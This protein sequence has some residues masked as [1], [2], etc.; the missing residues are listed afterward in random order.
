MKKVFALFL[1]VCMLFSM[2]ACAAKQPPANAGEENQKTDGT[3]SGEIEILWQIDGA[4]DIWQYTLD[5]F[6]EHYPDVKIT[7]NKDANAYESIGNRLR[8]GNPPDVFYTWHTAFDY[9]S[10]YKSGLLAPVDALM[11]TERLEG[12]MT[13]KEF[14]Q[15]DIYESGLYEGNHYFIPFQQLM[16]MSFYSGKTFEERNYTVPTTWDEF[17]SLCDQ[18]KADGE[19]SPVIYAGVY[20]EML[21]NTFVLNEIYNND[22]ET[23]NRIYNGEAAWNEPAAVAAV[24]RLKDMVDAGYINTDS[25]AIDHIQSQMDFINGKA[26][27][28]PAGSWMEN[29]MAGNWPDGFD[30]KPF[31]L[32]SESGKWTVMLQQGEIVIPAQPD[33]EKWDILKELFR[34]FFSDE[35]TYKATE[36]CGLLTAYQNIPDNVMALLS[37]TVQE[38]YQQIEAHECTVLNPI[39]EIRYGAV[40]PEYYNN[41]NGLVSGEYSVEDFCNNMNAAFE[42]LG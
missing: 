33:G 6:A 19:T 14:L 26:A 8:A 41:L 29:E 32:P 30:L 5:Y 4:E 16:Y 27:F 7:F 13:L 39:I 3:L 20:A 25:I 18:I 36:E 17:I 9:A 35:S 10:A 12:D 15:K 42:A 28:I 40:M 1:V 37:P 34:V 2:T 21:G 31:I 24:Q 22:P 11:E 38:M 23:L